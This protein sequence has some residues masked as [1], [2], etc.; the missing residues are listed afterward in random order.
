MIYSYYSYLAKKGIRYEISDPKEIKT[1]EEIGNDI[2]FELAKKTLKDRSAL[3]NK[4]KRYP[5]FKELFRQM[6]WKIHYENDYE[7]DWDAY[8]AKLLNFF[9]ENNPSARPRGQVIK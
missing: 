4:C 3:T 9:Y 8:H 2:S 7:I 6:Y 5:Q 1:R